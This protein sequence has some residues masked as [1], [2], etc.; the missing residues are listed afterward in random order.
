MLFNAIPR[1]F[2]FPEIES[3]LQISIAIISTNLQPQAPL[4]QA[5]IMALI[6]SFTGGPVMNIY[7]RYNFL[8][9]SKQWLQ[10]GNICVFNRPLCQ[11]IRTTLL[12]MV[13]VQTKSQL[14][15]HS[16]EPRR[17]LTDVRFS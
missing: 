2:Y 4:L 11:F 1:L 3:S 8:I 9:T 13:A 12:Q 10:F 14:Y 5:P 17:G 7:N 6:K 15:S 16:I